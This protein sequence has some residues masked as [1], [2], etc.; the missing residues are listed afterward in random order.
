MDY[1]IVIRAVAVMAGTGLVLGILLAVASRKLAVQINP[2]VE[3]VLQV[4]PGSNCGACGFAG[5]EPAAEAM[6]EGHAGVNLCRAGGQEVANKVARVLGKD[7][8]DV[9]VPE[10]ATCRCSGGCKISAIRYDYHGVPKCS[11][12]HALHGGPLVCQ[13]GCT[14]FG[15]CVAA[16]PFDAMVMGAEERPEI[17][18][19]KCTG[20]GVC[21]QTCPMGPEGLLSLVDEGSPIVVACSSQESP[22]ASRHACPRGCIACKMC[23]KVCP[24]DAIHVIDNLAVVDYEK[25]NGCGACVEKCPTECITLT[26]WAQP[27]GFPSER[28]VAEVTSASERR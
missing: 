26:R 24:V 6:A 23:E 5:C 9:G 11:A 10:V 15:D 3:A 2:H 4:L 17:I 27:G 7:Q 21:V 28:E 14:G 20:C 8:V 16:C 12:A 25:C 22:K 1:M 19:D 13:H 18:I